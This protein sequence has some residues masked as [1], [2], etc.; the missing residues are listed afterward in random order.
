MQAKNFDAIKVGQKASI[1]TKITEKELKLFLAL[2]GDYNPIHLDPTEAKRYGLRDNIVHGML[3][4]SFLSTLIGMKLPGPGAL[5]ISQAIEYKRPVYLNDELDIQATVVKKNE[6]LKILSLKIEVFNQEKR[7]VLEGKAQVK[8]L[9][10]FKEGKMV[11]KNKNRVAL[12]TGS[13]RGIGAQIAQLFANEGISVIVNYNRD[14]K[15]AEDTVQKI[16]ASRGKACSI[17]ADITKK[18]DLEALSKAIKRDFGGIDILVNNAT[19]GIDPI[20]FDE[21]SWEEVGRHIDIHIKAVFDLCK[22]FIPH[23]AEQKYGK[24]VN[25]ISTYGLG[26]PPPYLTH[27]V[28]A[29]SG[30][31]GLS[32]SLAVEFGPKGINVNM[33]SPGLTNTGLISGMPEKTKLVYASQSPMRRIAEPQDVAEAALFLVS[34]KARHLSGVNIP[35]SG[36]YF[37]F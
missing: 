1:K 3:P 12:I 5:W 21:L 16:K 13:S 10:T 11:K 35:V 7:I 2:T 6:V 18:S 23:M 8:M 29:K 31:I 32:K 25:I 15:S 28:I 22:T 33:I 19:F 36:G 27:Y 20:N 37:M 34:D 4:T 26:V 24:V 9:D 14:K 17:Q 30:L